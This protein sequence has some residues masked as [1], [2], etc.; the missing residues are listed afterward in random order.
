MVN[1]ERGKI[2]G[3][4]ENVMPKT[5]SAQRRR[6]LRADSQGKQRCAGRPCPLP[7]LDG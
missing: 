2:Q 4:N 5:S 7:D 3:G 6:R 1:K